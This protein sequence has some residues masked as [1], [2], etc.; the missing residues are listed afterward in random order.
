VS[1]QRTN[2]RMLLSVCTG[3]VAWLACPV[4]MTDHL[5]EVDVTTNDPEIVVDTD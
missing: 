4:A 1:D 5:Q 3:T 2:A